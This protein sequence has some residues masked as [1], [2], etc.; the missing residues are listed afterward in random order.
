MDEEGIRNRLLATGFLRTRDAADLGV[1]QHRL[2]QLV[3]RGTL[4]RV[5]AGVYVDGATHRA[6]EPVARHLLEVRAV[7]ALLGPAY[8]VSHLS[9][10]GVHGLPVLRRDLGHLELSPIGTGKPRRDGHVRVH[11]P[12]PASAVSRVGAVAVVEPAVAVVQAAASSGLRAGVIAADAAMARRAV[13]RESLERALDEI[14]LG[15]GRPEAALAVGFADERSESPGE[16]WA[17]LLFSQLGLPDME[18]QA[19]LCDGTGRFVARV[20]FLDH[21]HRLVIEFDGAVKY[22]GA[23]AAGRAALVAEKRR[24]DE[25]RR[26]GY[27]VLRF[28]WSDLLDPARLSRLVR[29]AQQLGRRSRLSAR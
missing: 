20:D 23:G 16:S 24:E 2:A 13:T 4:V 15:R 11:V 21:E 19:V 7:A 5:R 17:R 27:V 22:G 29:D 3:A 8:A 26:L 12:V 6:A 25:I 14:P 10:V 9:A 18:P 1:D 28:T